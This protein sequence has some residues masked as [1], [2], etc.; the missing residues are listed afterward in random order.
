LLGD[1][2]GNTAGLIGLWIRDD[3]R[4]RGLGKF[5]VGEVLRAVQADGVPQIDVQV[6]ET[7]AAALA[8]FRRLGFQQ[9]DRGYLLRKSL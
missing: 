4:G 3:L 5:L 2:E 6:A 9:A 8:V 7:N 1:V